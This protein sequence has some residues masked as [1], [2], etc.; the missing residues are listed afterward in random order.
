MTAP[1]VIRQE[2]GAALERLE[3][4]LSGLDAVDATSLRAQL[5]RSGSAGLG[6]PPI[7]KHDDAL[8]VGHYNSSVMVAMAEALVAQQARIEKLEEQLQAPEPAK[9]KPT[10]K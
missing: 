1:Q 9:D 10:K 8:G 2:R 5:E 7:P 6:R 3:E 4:V